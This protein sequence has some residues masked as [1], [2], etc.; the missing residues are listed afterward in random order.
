MALVLAF[1][2]FGGI[3]RCGGGA[4]GEG[5]WQCR[6]MHPIPTM[7]SVQTLPRATCLP[8]CR[9]PMPLCTDLH[10]TLPSPRCPPLPDVPRSAVMLPPLCH[11]E[12]RHER[13]CPAE[14]LSCPACAHSLP[15]S[16]PVGLSWTILEQLWSPTGTTPRPGRAPTVRYWMTTSE[17][18]WVEGREGRQRGFWGELDGARFAHERV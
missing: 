8:Q 4:A 9:L 2:A 15:L 6:L 5:R 10:V 3:V 12:P 16:E 14:F 18:S 11:T 13:S 17:Q 7:G 1:L